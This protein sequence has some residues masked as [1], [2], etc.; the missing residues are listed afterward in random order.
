MH[1]RAGKFVGT[2]FSFLSVTALTAGAAG[3]LFLDRIL[4][5]MNTPPEAWD[6]TASYIGVSL[7]GL[8]F[9]YGYNMVSA[10]LRGMGDS[11]HPFVFVAAAALLNI[12]LDLL[13]VIVFRWA[14]FGAA[15]ATV[16]SQALSFAWAAVFLYRNREHFGFDFK[17]RSFRPDPAQLKPLLK[18]GVP[19]LLQSASVGFSMVFVTAWINSYGLLAAAMTGIGNKVSMIVNVVNFSIGSA[20]GSMVGQAIGAEKYGRVPKILGVSF[21]INGAVSVCMGGLTVF[22][23]AAVF[24]LFTSDAELLA[25]AMTYIPVALVLFAGSAMRPPMFSLINGSGNFKLNL[26]VALLDGVIARIGLSLLLGLACGMGV[27]GFWY[28]NAL[29]GT[30]PFFVGGV[31]FLTGR[32]R[33]RKYII[34]S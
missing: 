3:L 1:D 2:L 29:A 31:Y 26:A 15:L 12:V 17:P 27:Y 19:M 23:P 24:G 8:F 14:I 25:F 32:W 30:V 20:G 9:M 28:G 13:F 4:E 22:A 10:V 16:L 18:L 34:Q 6:F 5:W 21:A 11:R 33:T 7:A